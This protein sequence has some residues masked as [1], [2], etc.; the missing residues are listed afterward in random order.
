MKIYIVDTVNIGKMQKV[1]ANMDGMI[2]Y[3]WQ[4][5][6]TCTNLC[7]FIAFSCGADYLGRE[8]SCLLDVGCRKSTMPVP[9]DAIDVFCPRCVR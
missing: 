8:S 6:T 7:V 3:K 4:P 9:F 5:R 1:V 2:L